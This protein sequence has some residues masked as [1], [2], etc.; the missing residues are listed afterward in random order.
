MAFTV[1]NIYLYVCKLIDGD[2]NEKGME[3]QRNFN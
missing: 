2:K 3:K 1:Y